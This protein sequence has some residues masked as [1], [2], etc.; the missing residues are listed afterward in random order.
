[1]PVHS[2]RPN[3]LY[4]GDEKYSG[5]AI[6]K[7]GYRIE[8]EATPEEIWDRIVK[9]GGQTG[10]YCGN[11]LWRLRGWLDK[12][13]GGTSLRRGRR[14]PSTLYV[15]D[16]LDFWRVLDIQAPFRLLLLSEMKLPGEA[17]LE[18][19]ITPLG[20]G[21]TELRRAF[22][23]PARRIPGIAVLVH[24]LPGPPMAFPRNACEQSRRRSENRY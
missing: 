19:K 4:C 3:G 22:A 17:I 8:I 2:C 21:R 6:M 12:V 5:G 15:G 10:W 16:A 9:I 11:R 14:H 18:F 24:P 1:M 13:L 20:H 23:L 7:C